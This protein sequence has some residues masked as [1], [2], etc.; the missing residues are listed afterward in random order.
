MSAI[1]GL[2]EQI[3]NE[4]CENVNSGFIAPANYNCIGQIVVSGEKQA[5]ADAM[6]M[7]KEKGAK[8]TVELKTSGP[9]HTKMLQEASNEL[10][11]ELDKIQF[12]ELKSKVIKNIDGKEYSKTENYSD[13]LALH[14][15]S[16]VRLV[17]GITTML[18][19]GIDTFIEVG[20]G[21]IL[22]GFVKRSSKD[23][24]ILNI[25]NV[26]TFEKLIEEL[27]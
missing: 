1:L 27:K 8:K 19:M 7:A 22:S 20:P 15:I 12:N 10:K 4:I 2:D 5:V 14:I 3:V 25:N 6:K 13:V 24:N 16:P 9:F 18:N 26:E 23:V 21:K 11:K 17:D